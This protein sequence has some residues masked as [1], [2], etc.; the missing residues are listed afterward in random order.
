MSN[1]GYGFDTVVDFAAKN[2]DVR[3]NDC[4]VINVVN[5]YKN[6]NSKFILLL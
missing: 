6:I 2:G 3:T 4:E 5:H 1:C